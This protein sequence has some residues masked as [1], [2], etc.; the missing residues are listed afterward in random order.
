MSPFAWQSNKA[1]LFLCVLSHF[2][3]VQLFV[4]AWTVAHQAHLSMGFSRQE[5]LSGLPFPTLGD[6]PHQGLSSRLLHTSCI[7][8]QTLYH[9]HHLLICEKQEKC[10]RLLL[11]RVN[12]D[13]LRVLCRII[14]YLEGADE[15]REGVRRRPGQGGNKVQVTL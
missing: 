12:E 3:R 4:T 1:I 7:G 14:P 8:R 6:L 13:S 9:W 5:Y 10:C 15:G 11:Y 2:S